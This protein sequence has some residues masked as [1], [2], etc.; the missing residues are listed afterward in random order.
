[1]KNRV[2]SLW[3]LIPSSNS[4]VVKIALVNK[5]EKNNQV[6]PVLTGVSKYLD[7]IKDEPKLSR[8]SKYV[9]R[10]ALEAKQCLV[11]ETSV[12]RYMRSRS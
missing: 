1:M 8:V 7:L 11:V 9:A 12:D 2:S 3:Q 6:K 4:L 10:Q 5:L